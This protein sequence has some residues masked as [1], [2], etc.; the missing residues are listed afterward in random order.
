MISMMG[1]LDLVA[2]FKLAIAE[3]LLAFALFRILK[4]IILVR[5]ILFVCYPHN[6]KSQIHHTD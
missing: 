2:S 3:H 5:S 4:S 1:L 6:N